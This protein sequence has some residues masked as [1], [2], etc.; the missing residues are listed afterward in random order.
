VLVDGQEEIKNQI[1]QQA[2]PV[3]RRG[4]GH[5]RLDQE[6]HRGDTAASSPAG[7][8]AASQPVGRAAATF[9]NPVSA[10][11]RG[12]PPPA[13]LAM[14]AGSRAGRRRAHAPP[15]APLAKAAASPPVGRAAATSANPTSVRARGPP[16]DHRREPRRARGL[17][18]QRRRE[19][20]KL[21]ALGCAGRRRRHRWQR[22]LS[23]GKM[24]RGGRRR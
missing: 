14:A 7:R 18:R 8:A 15:P 23:N 10:R 11:V 19:P 9:A 13:P 3:L 21:R 17:Q 1:E 20:S 5:A 6:K 22:A 16:H 2:V 24:A 4:D 12:S